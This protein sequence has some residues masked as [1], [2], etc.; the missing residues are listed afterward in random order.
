MKAIELNPGYTPA[1]YW[2]STTL[3]FTD[4]SD[5]ALR[6]N[7][8]AIEV[9]PLSIQAITQY[10]WNLS[11]LREYD[12]ATAQLKRALELNPD[13]VLAHWLLGICYCLQSRYDDAITECRRAV[14]LSDNNP[15]MLSTLGWMYG[16]S[17]R[18]AEARN[19][20]TELQE[21][22]EREYVR[23]IYFVLVY[24]GL[25]EFDQVFTWLDKAYE[26][27]DEWLIVM[28]SDPAFD[29]IRA[30]P[31]FEALLDKIKPE[32]LNQ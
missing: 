18:T 31:R 15:W 10:G 28:R 26:E 14:D 4:R 23:S 24:L 30:D 27:R 2:Y 8:R 9:D 19:V 5:E 11:G 20:L 12:R 22:F 1:L 16:M 3:L 6:K 7:R 17:G 21:R 32:P 25:E 29:C 13:Y